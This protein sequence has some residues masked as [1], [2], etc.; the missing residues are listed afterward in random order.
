MVSAVLR[1]DHVDTNTVKGS[2]HSL[3]IL[4]VLV[5]RTLPPLP[6]SQ[7]ER[8]A[9]VGVANQSHPVFRVSLDDNVTAAHTY[10]AKSAWNASMAL[11]P[12]F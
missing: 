6:H 9:L 1:V 8:C 4:L 11:V 12:L 5:L 3:A 10:S 7:C 2:H